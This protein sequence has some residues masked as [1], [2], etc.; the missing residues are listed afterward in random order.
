MATTIDFPL[1][2]EPNKIIF[3]EQS[4]YG[5]IKPL[6]TLLTIKTTTP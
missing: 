2:I 5:H 1:K 4:L 3:I 6:N